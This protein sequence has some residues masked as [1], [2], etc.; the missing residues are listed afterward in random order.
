MYGGSAADALSISGGVGDR[1]GHGVIN[2]R[3]GQGLV[4]RA[5]GVGNGRGNNVDEGLW[6]EGGGSRRHGGVGGVRLRAVDR[7]KSDTIKAE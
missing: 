4:R 3:A 6:Q 5:D 2:C 1:L 7:K